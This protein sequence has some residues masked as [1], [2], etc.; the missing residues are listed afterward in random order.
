DMSADKKAIA[1]HGLEDAY[2]ATGHIAI[3]TSPGATVTV[4]GHPVEGTAPFADQFDV[5]VGKHT[6]EA[7]LGGQSSKFEVEAKPGQVSSIELAIA[8]APAPPPLTAGT[9]LVIPP[10]TDSIP[11]PGAPAAGESDTAQP[12]PSSF[13]NTRREV[14]VAV[15]AAGVLALGASAF[16]YSQRQSEGNR[17]NSLASGLSSSGAC[18]SASPPASCGALQNAHDAE[19]RDNAWRE[20]FLGIGAA[21]I[22]GGAVMFLWPSHTTVSRTAIVPFFSPNG[23]GVQLRQEL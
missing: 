17:A 20:A 1:Q 9:S 12:T 10:A 4:D 3:V 5:T 22:V 8:P 19:N 15:G 21:A 23:G 6:F 11:P 16:F 18:A 2:G 13:W 14:G 7:H